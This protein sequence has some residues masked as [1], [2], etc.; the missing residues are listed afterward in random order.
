MARTGR[1][2]KTAAREPNGRLKRPTVDMLNEMNHAKAMAE[3]ATV[4][5]QPHRRGSDAP[6]CSSALGRFWLGLAINDRTLLHA[7]ESY[8]GLVRRW[9]AAWGAKEASVPAEGMTTGEGP[10]EKTVRAW[11]AEIDR[12]E[13]KLTQASCAVRFAIDR[14]V[15]EDR[16]LMLQSKLDAH[17]G[18][19]II[20]IELGMLGG[21]RDHPFR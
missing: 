2:R 16:D 19:R 13:A 11:R 12:I 9:R 5:A 15:V 3:T 1:K 20:A 4:R 18:L 6:E 14:L 10:S 21:R 17:L 8:A 7:G